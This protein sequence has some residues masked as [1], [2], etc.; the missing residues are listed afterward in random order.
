[1]TE[2]AFQCNVVHRPDMCDQIHGFGVHG[3]AASHACIDFHVYAQCSGGF[4]EL[5]FKGAYESLVGDGGGKAV[6]DDIGNFR[7]GG[8]TQN[9]DGRFNAADPKLNAF[10]G[11]CHAEHPGAF[12]QGGMG[13]LNSPVTICVS[14]DG[15]HEIDRAA[16]QPFNFPEIG[17]KIVQVHFHPAAVFLLVSQSH[18]FVI[19]NTPFQGCAGGCCFKVLH[20]SIYVV[21]TKSSCFILQASWNAA[22]ASS[23]F[24]SR[25]SVSPVAKTLI[26]F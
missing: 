20:L 3:P 9:D 18:F 2:E 21:D 5:F 4:L 24:P 13:N 26:R 8:R 1:M 6:F 16:D 15:L 10:I 25:Y 23:H 22:I 19:T 12:A 14:L 17:G 11:V 7:E